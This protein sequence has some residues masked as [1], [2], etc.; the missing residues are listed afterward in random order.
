MLA[1]HDLIIVIC[2]EAIPNH[3]LPERVEPEQDREEGG[4]ADPGDD[5]V[6]CDVVV[7][8]GECGDDECYE[9][10]QAVDELL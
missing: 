3:L 5:E 2:L 4:D 9:D 10:G 8:V 7:V 6:D 1:Q